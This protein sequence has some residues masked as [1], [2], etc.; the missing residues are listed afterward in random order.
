MGRGNEGH[1]RTGDCI[2]ESISYRRE[3]MY[4]RVPTPMII[5]W[6]SI[7]KELSLDSACAG[8]EAAPSSS[9]GYKDKA[10]LR[11]P[12]KG[13]WLVLGGGHSSIQNQHA[14]SVDQRFA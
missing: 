7:R 6:I 14:V 13:D 8:A 2:G 10:S 12:F 1:R 9:L 3:V 11:L 5:E 4:Q